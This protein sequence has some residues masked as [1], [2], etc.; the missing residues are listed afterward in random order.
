MR[1][2]DTNATIEHQRVIGHTRLI[3]AGQRAS[4]SQTAARADDELGEH[5]MRI[6]ARF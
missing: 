5:I 2:A 3:H 1:L 4:V 6:E